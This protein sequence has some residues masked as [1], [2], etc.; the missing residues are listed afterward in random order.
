MYSTEQKA[1]TDIAYVLRDAGV[2]TSSILNEVAL[3]TACAKASSNTY[4]DVSLHEQQPDLRYAFAQMASRL[5]EPG[6]AF[7]HS[8]LPDRLS[9]AEI[10]SVLKGLT[11]LLDASGKALAENLLILAE[12]FGQSGQMITAETGQF[13]TKLCSSEQNVTVLHHEASIPALV[14]SAAAG[15]ATV[16]MR[17][18]SPFAI[19]VSFLMEANSRVE[20]SVGCDNELA[21]SEFVI[22]V[23]PLQATE[24]SQT[25][26][27][28]SD[29]LAALRV[30]RECSDRGVVCVA[31]SVLFSRAAMSVREEL[32]NNNW[33]DA[34]IGLP[35]GT[36]SNTA[37]PPV[38]L[39]IDKHREKNAPIAFVDVPT[40]QTREKM[41]DLASAVREKREPENGAFA[42]NLDIQKN[43]YDLT[44]SRYKLGLAAQELKRLENTVLL[45]GVAEIVRAQS[46]KDAEDSSG[47]TA[48]LEASV[49]D[50]TE[51]GYLGTPI[52]SMQI[53]KKQLRRAQNQRIYPGDILLAVKGSVGR[54]AFVD[55]ACGDNWI[56]GQAFIIIRPKSANIST[57]YLYRYLVSQ[58][59][60]KYMQEIATGGVMA[61]LKA[62][63]VSG[64]PV[65]LP[66]PKTLKSV[67]E[68]HQQILA[69]Y[70]VIKAHRDTI[71]RLELQN[72]PLNAKKGTS[73]A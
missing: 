17:V 53:D 43:D 19:A 23:P 71:N 35:K 67:E 2:P 22:S 46:L 59:I 18:M 50:I 47:A 52:K 27:L 6:Y 20:G 10:T 16:I 1:L 72:W 3:L 26:K 7:E 13:L 57:P 70:D 66:E 38:I 58:L 44:I 65:P 51:S 5:G 8:C 60:Q 45:E 12:K 42:S 29:E 41:D 31:P 21:S 49:R 55:E 4:G 15:E 40:Y 39:V 14:A 37:V 63:D 32:I 11:Q 68:T 62:A 54:V 24:F 36:L 33:L 48:F 73:R 28:K 64:I 34:V 61:L 69:E 56:A 9:G 25:S 30:A